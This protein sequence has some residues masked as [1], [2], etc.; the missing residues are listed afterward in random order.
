MGS[1]TARA[2]VLGS[3]LDKLSSGPDMAA[4]NVAAYQL[5]RIHNAMIGIGAG[6]DYAGLEVVQRRPRGREP[7]LEVRGIK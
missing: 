6:Q 1:Q 5:A 4:R 7:L 2:E 3:A